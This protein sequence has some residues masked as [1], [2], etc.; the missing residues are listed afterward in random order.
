[1]TEPTPGPPDGTEPARTGPPDTVLLR[2]GTF[3]VLLPRRATAV[4]LGLG[5]LAALAVAVSTV[6]GPGALGMTDAVRA[7]FGDGYGGTV[8]LVRDIRLPR[9]VAGLLAG[10]GLG[11]A[12]CL[13]QTLARNRLATPDLLGINDGGTVAVLATAVGSS[14]GMVG[15]WWAGPIGA[16]IAAVLVVLAAGGLGT[17]GYRLLVVG[18]AVS[19]MIGA[20]TN[21]ALARGNLNTAGGVF[22]WTIGSLNGRGYLVAVPVGI[23]LAF[24][25]PLAAVA[26]RQL[27][28]LRFDDDVAATL[29]V[30]LTLARL[31]VL[32]L[33]VALAGL[34]VG[35][36]GPLAFVA[37]A[38]P[39]VAGKLTGARRVPVI[40]AAL[41][42]AV[43]VVISDAIGRMAGPAEIPVGVVTSALGGPFLLWVL[44]SDKATR[45]L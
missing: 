1:M 20:L 22:L 34:A 39:I 11:A 40:G 3:S 35:I 4:A 19:S 38:S 10:A 9:I 7:L 23:A 31:F 8:L 6:L 25:I 21:L 37:M 30:N 2:H 12:G 15:A 27:N 17:Q 33:A 43:L 36:G 18:L 24:L 14:T 42:G 13:T 28:V 16:I 44:L 45:K 41:V 32:A 26:G 5:V 29:G